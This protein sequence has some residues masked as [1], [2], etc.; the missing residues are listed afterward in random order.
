MSAA[1]EKQV[2]GR[3]YG[4]GVI[5]HWD[6]VRLALDNRY[7]EGNASK[8]IFRWRRKNGIQD[9]EKAH[10][11]IEKIREVF[12]NGPKPPIDFRSGEMAE[13]FCQK[14]VDELR[15]DEAW[16]LCALATWET[17][18]DLVAMLNELNRMIARAKLRAEE[19]REP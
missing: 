7:L 14:H 12:G 2:G 15:P 10:H 11:Y 5:Q 8:Y 18:A 6:Y 4:G 16:L 17:D 19:G 1:N 13:K 9:L 3:H